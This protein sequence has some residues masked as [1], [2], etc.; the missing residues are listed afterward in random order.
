M[1]FGAAYFKANDDPQ[2]WAASV[3]AAGY[4]A[5][6]C[7]IDYTAPPDTVRAYAGA[8][9]AADVVIAEVGAWNNPLSA[10]PQT[11]RDAIEKCQR[12]LALA[13]EVGARCCVN[14]A[15]S[16]GEQWA[17]PHPA[18][19]TGETFDQIVQC[20]RNILD[21]VKPTRT[22]YAL[23]T[24]PWM[25][26]D[27]ADSYGQLIGAI[28]RK[29]FAAHL[30]PVNLVCSP[31]RYY[32]NAE[33]I[34]ECF[35]KLG[36]HIKSCHGKDILLSPK[37]T[38]HLDEVRPGLGGLDYAVYLRELGRLDPDTPMLLEHLPNEA[39]YTLA[40]QH[41]RAVANQVGVKIR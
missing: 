26:P 10:D 6:Y 28:D 23:E 13:D 37:L 17:G 9:A 29:Q 25:Y 20:V 32:A 18:N 19:L 8:A 1:R 22:F 38:V 31:Q 34:R 36:K 4:S 40:A 2:T 41:I 16:R 35:R 5:A 3:R 27:S 24:M 21:A 15:G 30:D 11:R 14:V 39:E 12:Q 33:L 7:P